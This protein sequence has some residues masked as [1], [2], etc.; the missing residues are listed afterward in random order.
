MK[1]NKKV[2]YASLLPLMASVHKAEVSLMSA[3]LTLWETQEH[4]MKPM[5]FRAGFV[6]FAVA[7]GYDK[8]WAMEVCVEAGFRA[9]AAGG[10]RKKTK[11]AKDTA[12]AVLAQAK[13]LPAKELKRL[14]KM[15]AAI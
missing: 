4:I 6:A 8:R 7:N 15:L 11:P 14:I 13:A 10:G 9:R 2:N 3:L 1:T 12:E 5:E